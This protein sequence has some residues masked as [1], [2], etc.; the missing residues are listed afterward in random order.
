MHKDTP[1]GIDDN[2]A[3]KPSTIEA[4]AK[5]EQKRK[6]RRSGVRVALRL[7]LV[8]MLL[9][10]GGAAGWWARGEPT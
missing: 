3:E 4:D 9:V 10:V 6:Q 8:L 5:P 2:R 7:G 1:Q